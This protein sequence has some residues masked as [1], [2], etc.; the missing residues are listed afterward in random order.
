AVLVNT[1]RGDT[2]DSAALA[3]ALKEGWIAGAAMD[4]LDREPP[5]PDHPLLALPNVICTG[6]VAYYS[7]EARVAQAEEACAQVLAF[8]QGDTPPALVNREV[9]RQKL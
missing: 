9:L 4:V 6:H 3:R 7:E 2:V 5:P 1:S 8:L